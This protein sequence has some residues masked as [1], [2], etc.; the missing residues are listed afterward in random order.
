MKFNFLLLL[1]LLL[2]SCSQKD[3]E[4]A[5]LEFAKNFP[6]DPNSDDDPSNDTEEGDDNT[7][8]ADDDITPPGPAYPQNI[9]LQLSWDTPTTREDCSALALNEIG[10]YYIYFGFQEG[11]WEPAID[12]PDNTARAHN[13]TIDADDEYHFAIET[14]TTDGVTSRK[15][16]TL[17]VSCTQGN[18]VSVSLPPKPGT[19][20]CPITSNNNTAGAASTRAERIETP[21]P[22]DPPTPIAGRCPNFPIKNLKQP[23]LYYYGKNLKVT[24][25]AYRPKVIQ[26][27]WRRHHSAESKAQHIKGVAE[28]NL[29]LPIF[30]NGEAFKINDKIYIPYDIAKLKTADKKALLKKL[31]AREGADIESAFREMPYHLRG[32]YIDSYN[33]YLEDRLPGGFALIDGANYSAVTTRH[34]KMCEDEDEE[35][36]KE[37]EEETKPEKVCY[38]PEQL[39]KSNQELSEFV[40]NNLR[41]KRIPVIELSFKEGAKV[42]EIIELING[43]SEVK[44]FQKTETGLNKSKYLSFDFSE[45]IKTERPYYKDIPLTE[46]SS[47]DML[48]VILNFD[49]ENVDKQ[50]I[51]YTNDLIGKNDKLSPEKIRKKAP[52]LV[53]ALKK[54]WTYVP[55]EDEKEDVELKIDALKLLDFLVPRSEIE[56]QKIVN[57][58]FKIKDANVA[59]GRGI[60]ADARMLAEK[61]VDKVN[62]LFSLLDQHKKKKI[63]QNVLYRL[64][65]D[66]IFNEK[67]LLSDDHIARVIDVRNLMMKELMPNDSMEEYEYYYGIS[68]ATYMKALVPLI[69]DKK[70]TDDQSKLFGK[71]L[72]TFKKYSFAFNRDY[73]DDCCGDGFSEEYV[74]FS[75]DEIVY[76]IFEKEV[77]DADVYTLDIM[78]DFL[79]SD[80]FVRMYSLKDALEK[81]KKYLFENKLER[82]QFY[83]IRS[84]FDNWTSRRETFLSDRQFALKIAEGSVI[85]VKT[86][87]YQNMRTYYYSYRK[88]P[89]SG[90][91]YIERR[92]ILNYSIKRNVNNTMSKAQFDL[93]ISIARWLSSEFREEFN[94]NQTRRKVTTYVS[95]EGIT[96]EQF[97]ELKAKF[98]EYVKDGIPKLRA[99]RRAERRILKSEIEV[100]EDDKP[101]ESLNNRR[102]R[103]RRR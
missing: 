27:N 45:S 87:H 75:F 90:Q 41:Y 21:T 12:V 88:S 6:T 48:N 53:E 44:F 83:Q 69:V 101:F 56:N 71:F 81:A 46:A 47:I 4:K 39:H 79:Y 55:G 92:R 72:K 36:N 22:E 15:S 24:P 77:K 51:K 5:K 11:V 62:R 29:H 32:Q 54:A 97:N 8:G 52:K 61:P 38:K 50:A 16:A 67:E 95:R 100:S 19:P 96:T 94:F 59:W 20:T 91:D 42:D 9:T 68:D 58:F 13:F 85:G 23:R 18:C 70:I 82:G 49:H 80:K 102:S 40:T 93:E 98:R 66:W 86:K 3:V 14:Y 2:G 25:G 43:D 73:Y 26:C 99:L 76:Y 34:L 57:L 17:R 1:L 63:S 7:G 65:K 28:V 31:N 78:I 74:R 64:F 33:G 30:R 10:G 37:D 103:R 84:A 89:S 60:L 35:E